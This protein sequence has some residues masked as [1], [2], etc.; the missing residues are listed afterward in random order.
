MPDEFLQM[1]MRDSC[2]MNETALAAQRKLKIRY[3][4]CVQDWT[5]SIVDCKPQ[6]IP[7]NH[8]ARSCVPELHTEVNGEGKQDLFER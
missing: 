2:G 1:T 4:A 8:G 7:Q 3:L 5:M 6:S